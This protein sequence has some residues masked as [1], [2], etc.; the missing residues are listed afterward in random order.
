MSSPAGFASTFTRLATVLFSL[1]FA[2]PA[3]AQMGPPAGKNG[4]AM[5]QVTAGGSILGVPQTALTEARVIYT[6]LGKGFVDGW[7]EFVS[8]VE[9]CSSG[10]QDALDCAYACYNELSPIYQDLPPPEEVLGPPDTTPWPGSCN[11]NPDCLWHRC[12]HSYTAECLS[13]VEDREVQEFCSASENLDVPGCPQALLQALKDER[14]K[15]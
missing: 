4:T 14:R 9:T 7:E 8:C 3:A 10:G 15:R 13:C 12:C 5:L 2:S 1:A 6:V 11:G